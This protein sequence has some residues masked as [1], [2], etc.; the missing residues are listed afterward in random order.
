MA[1]FSRTQARPGKPTRQKRTVNPRVF[2]SRRAYS[3]ADIAETLNKHVRTV[4]RWKNEGLP[5]L[6]DGIKP[7]LV[8]GRD[9]RDFIKSQVVKRKK[10]LQSGQ[11]FCPK[12]QQPTRSSIENVRLEFTQRRLGACHQQVIIHGMCEVCG[13]SL[14]LFSTEQKAAEW[15]K[16]AP[17][18]SERPSALNGN[19]PSSTNADIVRI[20]RH[21]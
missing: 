1:K 19:E 8:M 12:C 16:N 18:L 17:T 13:V 2:R 5:I 11:F 9:L 6:D 7:F 4:Q 21:D 10:P 20:D 14:T 15:R 3:F